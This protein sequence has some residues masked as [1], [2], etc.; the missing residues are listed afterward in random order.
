MRFGGFEASKVGAFPRMWQ[1]ALNVRPF[2]PQGSNLLALLN[3][4]VSLRNE[5]SVFYD[6]LSFEPFTRQYAYPQ[7]SPITEITSQPYVEMYYLR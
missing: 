7:L 6:Q 4:F 5:G 1:T 3:P 2:V